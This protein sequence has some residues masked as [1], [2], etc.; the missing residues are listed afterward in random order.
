MRYLLRPSSHW[1]RCRNVRVTWVNRRCWFRPVLRFDPFSSRSRWRVGF[2]SCTIGEI[3]LKDGIACALPRYFNHPGPKT[4][5]TAHLDSRIPG[6][7]CYHSGS[8]PTVER[9]KRYCDDRRYRSIPHHDIR[10]T[11][12]L[13]PSLY[14]CSRVILVPEPVNDR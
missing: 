14:L 5:C 13:S 12:Y 3:Q 9:V 2:R 4:D 1:R 6:K 8:L 7:E 10:R 11:D